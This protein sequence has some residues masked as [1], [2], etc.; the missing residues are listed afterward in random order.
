M[1]AKQPTELFWLSLDGWAA[2]GITRL[3]TYL[4]AEQPAIQEN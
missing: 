4:A 3:R 2:G 1:A